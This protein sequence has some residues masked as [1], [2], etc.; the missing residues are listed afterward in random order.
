MN[1]PR[2]TTASSP[3]QRPWGRGLYYACLRYLRVVLWRQGTASNDVVDSLAAELTSI[4][5]DH[6]E[7]AIEQRGEWEVVSRAID[8]MA[9][10]H[11]GPWQGKAS[12]QSTLSVLMELAVP[13]GGLDESGAAFLSDIQRGVNESYQSAPVEKSQLRV[14]DEVA[15]MVRTLTEAGCE[16]GLVSD[17]LDLCEEIFHGDVM[18][19]ADRFTLLV[20]AT[21]APFVRQER[22]ERKIDASGA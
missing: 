22:K 10:K 17:L 1:E 11:D 18:S 12:F 14:T 4:A 21:A 9:A 19:D 6:A 8:Y 15:A 16:Y 3:S 13:N 2:D 20:A 7:W 5:E